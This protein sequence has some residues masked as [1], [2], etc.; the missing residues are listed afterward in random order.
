MQK[1]IRTR[2]TEQGITRVQGGQAHSPIQPCSLFRLPL[3]LGLTQRGVT[4]P[5]RSPKVSPYTGTWALPSLFHSLIVPLG[6]GW[7]FFFFF[8]PL[9]LKTKE[10]VFILSSFLSMSSF[11]SVSSFLPSFP[12]SFPLSL[13]TL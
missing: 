8:K 3:S 7:V 5:Q 13:H 4:P 1:D 2:G 9:F 11:Y 6:M 12:A 10:T